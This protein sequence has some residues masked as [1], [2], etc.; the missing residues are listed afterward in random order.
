M[1]TFRIVGNAQ[2]RGIQNINHDLVAII[3][4]AAALSPYDVQLFSGKRNNDPGSSHFSGNAV[5][6]F[7]R[8]QMAS[9][10]QT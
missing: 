1:G 10:Y 8:P 3:R 9:K 7:S 5:D 6:M 2:S 4:Q